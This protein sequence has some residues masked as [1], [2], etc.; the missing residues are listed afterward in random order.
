MS[1][2]RPLPLPDLPSPPTSPSAA[3]VSL[4]MLA[5]MVDARIVAVIAPTGSGP[6]DLPERLAELGFIAGERV[7]VL[8][9]APFGDPLAVR[10]G[11][12][13]FALRRVEADCI[14]VVPLP[15]SPR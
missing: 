12:G 15:A 8:A 5:A 11:S 6:A 7:R 9:R 10:V 1:A 13:T 4:T 3:P 14:R 2:E